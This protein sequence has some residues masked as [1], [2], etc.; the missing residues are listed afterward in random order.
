MPKSWLPFPRVLITGSTTT[1]NQLIVL[2]T[3]VTRRSIS[4]LDPWFQLMA[5]CIQ[6]K[7]LPLWNPWSLEH[8]EF[9]HAFCISANVKA[10]WHQNWYGQTILIPQLC[11]ITCLVLKNANLTES[12]R[13]GCIR[14]P[15]RSYDLRDST[16]GTGGRLT[17]ANVRF[18]LCIVIQRLTL[19]SRSSS[20]CKT[21]SAWVS[22]WTMPL[23]CKIPSHVP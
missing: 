5:N 3:A 23:S 9:F 20:L 13:D 15:K 17:G 16:Y 6:Q 21:L 10:N 8:C 7:R 2:A 14:I 11:S 1:T 22:L 12:Q 18:V 19:W 4:V